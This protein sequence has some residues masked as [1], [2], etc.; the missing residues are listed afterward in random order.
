MNATRSHSSPSF[1]LTC[2][3]L[4]Q[5]VCWFAWWRSSFDDSP[6]FMV[7]IVAAGMFAI[8]CFVFFK[9]EPHLSRFGLLAV[10]L[11]PLLKLLLVHK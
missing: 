2:F 5:V 8:W 7:W 6:F 11:M 10:L 9:R 3:L 4:L 1:R